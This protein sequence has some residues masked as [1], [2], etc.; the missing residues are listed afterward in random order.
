[1]STD[2]PSKQDRREADEIEEIAEPERRH[3]R[4]RT[5][6]I[7]LA[8]LVL[9]A[10]LLAS[11][12]GKDPRA[13]P[14]ELIGK[15][16][17]EFSLPRIDA[18][19]TISSRDLAGQVVILNF[20]ASWCQPC[21]QEHDDLEAAWGRYRERGVVVLGV[22]FEDTPE[23]A[24]GFRREL[25]GDWPI[26]DDPGSKTA[27]A[28]GVFGVPET[29]VIAPDGTIAAKTTGAVTY[30]WLTDQIEGALREGKLE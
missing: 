14:S 16:A 19:G 21:R 8:P 3:P 13:L 7:V 22:S 18:D 12:L 23:G 6:A 24:M 1:M 26:A 29:F 27:I 9:F 4:T 30:E 20:W 11:G 5:I 17:P 2:A 15:P 25:G 28:Y 10:L